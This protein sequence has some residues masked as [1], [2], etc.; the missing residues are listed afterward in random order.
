MRPRSA[1][2]VQVSAVATPVAPLAGTGFFGASG[3]SGTKSTF[4]AMPP[5]LFHL[6][7]N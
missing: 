5:V 1:V 6:R 3:G 7:S 4:S 2:P